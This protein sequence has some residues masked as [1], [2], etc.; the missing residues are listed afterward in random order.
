MSVVSPCLSLGICVSIITLGGASW[1]GGVR[2]EVRLV[3]EHCQKF[4]TAEVPSA[5]APL[6][7]MAP[8]PPM[9]VPQPD[10]APPAHYQNPPR[11][12][13][14]KGSLNENDL[15]DHNHT[16][17]AAPALLPALSPS[18]DLLS[19]PLPK[20]NALPEPPVT[21]DSG[22]E[23]ELNLRDNNHLE[24]GESAI[25]HG[26]QYVFTAQ[27]NDYLIFGQAAE[28]AF[29]YVCTE[30]ALKSSSLDN[31]PCS[32]YGAMQCPP[33]ERERWYKAAVDKIQTLVDNGTFELVQLPPGHNPIGS[34]WVFKVKCNAD[35][36]VE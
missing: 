9:Q 16:L 3:L 1:V 2:V 7:P 21:L 14:Y 5:P 11:A 28:V 36:S 27:C 32:F 10:P 34:Y 33:E 24:Q 31:E 26:L 35:R 4:T 18:P 20:A 6:L 12:S 13:C 15:S 19:M 17:P 29:S 23:D 30:L 25:E 22:S 8:D